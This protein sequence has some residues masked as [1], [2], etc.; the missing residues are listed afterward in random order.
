MRRSAARRECAPG[1]QSRVASFPLLTSVAVL[2]H[3]SFLE[4]KAL[5][6]HLSLLPGNMSSV[7][8]LAPSQQQI[9]SLTP[10]VC[11]RVCKTKNN[12]NRNVQMLGAFLLRY[13]FW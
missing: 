7:I 6:V 4:M 5:L 8:L 2:S 11:V 12:E 10:E 1:S 9:S 13:D 3:D